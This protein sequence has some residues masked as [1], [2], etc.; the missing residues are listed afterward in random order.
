M[1]LCNW[2][3]NEKLELVYR[4]SRDGY[5]SNRFHEKCDNVSN[6]LTIVKSTKGY[7]FGGFTSANWYQVGDNGHYKVDPKA[8]IF[9]LKNK[10]NLPIKI[11][12][13]NAQKAIVCNN[14]WGP[15]FGNDLHIANNSDSNN[16]SQSDISHSYRST[17]I[18]GDTS[19]FLAG[20]NKFQVLDVEVYKVF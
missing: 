16:N 8:F 5:E 1:N 10:E 19:S 13:L 20:S 9:S 14:N 2:N 18:K 15:V 17:K 12:V 11:D 7:I 4:A 3:D 6:T